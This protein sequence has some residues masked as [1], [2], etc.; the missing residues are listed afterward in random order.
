MKKI[1]IA[2]G[3]TGGHLFPGLALAEE[4]RRRFD[5]LQVLFVGTEGGIEAR[6]LPDRGERVAFIPVK[7]LKGRSA[8]GLAKSAALLPAAV[9]RSLTLL[10]SFRPD[11]VVGVGG[12]A[13]GPMLLGAVTAGVPSA[14]LEQNSVLGMTNR[15]L[16]P[17]V[18]RAYHTFPQTVI[19]RQRT[20]L[21]GNPIRRSLVDLA[22]QS[23]ADP[24]GFEARCDTV[25]VLGGSAGAKTINEAVPPA[26][27]LTMRDLRQ[28]RHNLRVVHQ[29]GQAMLDDVRRRYADLQIDADVRPFIED[30]ESLYRRAALVIGRAGATTLAELTALGRPSL[31]IPYPYAADNHQSSNARSLVEEGAARCIEEDTLTVER[32]AMELQEL[33]SRPERRLGMATAARRLGRPDAAANIVDD[34]HEWI[35]WTYDEH[36]EMR[37]LPRDFRAVGAPRHSSSA[38]RPGRADP[39][40]IAWVRAQLQDAVGLSEVGLT[41]RLPH[42]FYPAW[43]TQAQDA[44]RPL[45]NHGAA[46]NPAHTDRDP[47]IRADEDACASRR[48]TPPMVATL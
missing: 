35:A 8:S 45:R 27:A 29:T 32:L 20:R 44:S 25:V 4:L 24:E 30:M 12:Y 3:G 17:L 2:G 43:A 46:G 47:K 7:P 6:V 9:M 34:L 5:D 18:D 16:S 39:Q 31:L 21:M 13:S 37:S 19:H 14:L 42:V 23:A 36:S 48:A 11:L 40:S 1:L 22:R 15:M 10:R 33:L 41:P 26:L 28:Q 38:S